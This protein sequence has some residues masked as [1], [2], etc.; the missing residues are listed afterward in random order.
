[1]SNFVSNADAATLFEAVGKKKLTVT[2]TMPTAA[3]ANVGV[4][5]LYLGA[6]TQD[7]EEGGVY[8]CQEI[9]PATDPKT[10]EYIHIFTAKVDLSLYKRIFGGTVDAW[11]LL[12]DEQKAQYEYTFFDGDSN[13][14]FAVVDA[15]T[16]GDMHPVTSNAVAEEVED[17]DAEIADITD[18][19][20]AKNLLITPY[21]QIKGGR[22]VLNGLTI[23]ENA[24]GSVTINGTANAQTYIDLAQ[25]ST[26]LEDGNYILSG[27]IS[28]LQYIYINI[29]NNGT[30]V[31]TLVDTRAGTSQFK[32]DYNGYDS[33][34]VGIS[35]AS[36]EILDNATFYPM[37]RYASVKD[38][39]YVPYAKTN[40]ELTEDSVDW[41]DMSKLGVVN[42]LDSD[43]DTQ[44]INGAT[45]TN[46]EDGSY[47]VSASSGATANATVYSTKTITLP[48]GIYKWTASNDGKSA[49]G[50]DGCY[51]FIR[52]INGTVNWYRSYDGGDYPYRIFSV[53]QESTIQFGLSI[54]KNTVI[55]SITFYPMI[56]LVSSNSSFVPY[57]MTNKEL[58]DAY[59]LISRRFDVI[60]QNAF[61][62]AVLPNDWQSGYRFIY[63]L[64]NYGNMEY[65]LAPTVLPT[66][67]LAI[68]KEYAMAYND[69]QT[70]V[71]VT[72]VIDS[73][74]NVTLTKKKDPQSKLSG[75]WFCL[76]R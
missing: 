52:G 2:D 44:T 1:M 26:F 27:G 51:A 68:G 36:G 17:L 65:L 24:D 71:V 6:D 46:N 23:K 64:I 70:A 37:I 73:S 11:D 69:G 20:G 72:F 48:K 56:T 47:T 45:F 43:I 33:I 60:I 3:E 5:Y 76:M 63:V 9:T 30:Y 22:I 67:S 13:D 31:R 53:T 59:G 29:L 19:Y 38:D 41:D 50:A 74:N 34:T 12:T 40:L 42:L 32:I 61:S 28:A 55:S 62:T 57:A 7:F 35:I 66:E 10:Y 14:Y 25:K 58:T 39:A 4:S 16:D 15:V 21:F 8:K 75:A 18:I 49:I 54:T